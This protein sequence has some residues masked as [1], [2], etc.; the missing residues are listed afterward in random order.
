MNIK[1]SQIIYSEH[2]DDECFEYLDG[3]GRV[4][5]GDAVGYQ[6]ES[7]APNAIVILFIDIIYSQ[8]NHDYWDNHDLEHDPDR[9]ILP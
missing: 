9:L 3:R 2:G 6:I 7:N 1:S 5:D 8:Y 4:N